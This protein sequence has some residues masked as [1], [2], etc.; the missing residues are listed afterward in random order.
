MHLN[1]KSSARWGAKGESNF[2]NSPNISLF[3]QICCKINLS[4]HENELNFIKILSN[5]HQILIELFYY[6]KT[7]KI[8]ITA[9]T[10]SKPTGNLN[11]PSFVS[12]TF[13]VSFGSGGSGVGA[14]LGA[15]ATNDTRNKS[16]VFW[17]SGLIDWLIWQRGSRRA[18]KAALSSTCGN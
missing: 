4:D 1:H 6:Q 3:L 17:S 7:I 8:Q 9:K 12:I 14:F 18:D 10:I 5:I 15:I 2:N 13:G 16:V 11:E